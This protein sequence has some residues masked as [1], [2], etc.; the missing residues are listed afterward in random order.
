MKKTVCQQ[1][2]GV[3]TMLVIILL[4]SLAG[5]KSAKKD[6]IPARIPVYNTSG[7]SRKAIIILPGILGSNLLT[8]SDGTPLW[9][10]DALAGIATNASYLNADGSFNMLA[11]GAHLS[12]FLYRDS[13]GKTA[14][15]VRAA[16]MKDSGLA[17]GTGGT[18]EELWR[19]LETSFGPQTAYDRDV[20]VFQYD[21]TQTNKDSAAD[22]ATFIA[23]NH[24]EDLI[25]IGHSMGGNVID[26]YLAQGASARATVKEVI[27]LGTPHLGALD[28]AS[29]LLTASF[30]QGSGFASSD[31]FAS[32]LKG[33]EGHY[34]SGATDESS[35]ASLLVQ[36]L[37]T[38]ART[39]P[40]VHELMPSTGLEAS[41]PSMY[42]WNGT[43]TTT[44]RLQEEEAGL[45]W[46]KGSSF[47]SSLVTTL[48]ARQSSLLVD[49]VL[50]SKTVAHDYFAGDGLATTAGLTLSA[51]DGL[52]LLSGSTS[53]T[54]GD[55]T[56]LTAS[57]L[58][59]T[60]GA[61]THVF[62]GVSHIG[63]V[64]VL[65]EKGEATAVGQEIHDVIV[66]ILA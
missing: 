1:L 35:F 31:Y 28:A 46:T 16:S 12:S 63:L 6:T 64:D 26:E 42:L 32:L 57:A 17:Y 59:G 40:S 22:L 30:P 56:V 23:Q 9:T 44:A 58:A 33:L 39:L 18:Y 5:C 60:D 14:T 62:S 45:L 8:L 20:V 54:A 49:G 53:T 50:V 4:V 21:W 51:D 55:G 38:F 66:R 27:T 36:T 11:F 19:A 43:S 65:D 48:S 10:T 61:S 13:T 3:L 24:Y 29:L 34:P 47:I 37:A 52:A 41:F 15:A 2:S 7:E 25:L